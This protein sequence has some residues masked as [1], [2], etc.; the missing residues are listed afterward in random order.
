MLETIREF[1]AD[2][3]QKSREAEATRTRHVEHFL[4]FAEAI[5]PA[6]HGPDQSTSLDR[7]DADRDNL[8]AALMSSP[9]DRRLKIAAALS[10]FWQLRSYLSEGQRWIEQALTETDART[11]DRARAMD[12]AGR[13]AFYFGEQGRDCRLLEDSSELMLLLGDECGRAR[14]LAYLGIAAGNAG[15]AK[16]ARTAGEEAVALSRAT[17]DEWTQAL[18][19]WGLGT[20]F[21][22][23][24]CQPPDNDIG[25]PLLEESA[26]LFRRTGD[27]WGLVGPLLYLA[28]VART[29]GNLEAAQRLLS[30]SVVL[31][32][33]VGDK[34]RLN[35]ALQGLGDLARSQGDEPAARA[36]YTEALEAC[37]EMSQTEAIADAQLKLALTALDRGDTQDAREFLGESLNGYRTSA[38]REGLLWVL[39]GCSLL[40]ARSGN[41][42]RAAVLLGASER[43]TTGG[44][45]QLGLE[46]RVRLE[47][48]LRSELGEGRFEAA[49]AEGTATSLDSTIELALSELGRLT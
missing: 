20:N 3:L 38:S 48:N 41:S 19:L 40:A 45:V 9:P 47:A 15:D 26:A 11:A 4:R 49:F 30:E 18:A 33:E 36:F 28:R 42:P 34:F 5:E 22:L 13:L 35:I 23:G 1:A 32:R 39:E 37:R 10:W 29:S 31:L 44:G 25:A 8:R 21:V 12:G 14:S 46:D 43:R 24:R 16:R 17:G 2:Q 6:L 7:L 27:R